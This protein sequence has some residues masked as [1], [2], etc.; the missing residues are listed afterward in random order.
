MLRWDE[1]LPKATE[2]FVQDQFTNE[3]VH[4]KIEVFFEEYDELQNGNKVVWPCLNAFWFSKDYLLYRV[5][6]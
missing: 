4:R 5:Q 6:C 2:R 1:I 3:A